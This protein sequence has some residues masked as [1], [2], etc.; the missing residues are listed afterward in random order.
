MD[1]NPRESKGT[2]ALERIAV[3]DNRLTPNAVVA[4]DVVL[5]TL[6]P[7]TMIE[8]RWQVLLLRR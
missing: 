5:F 8:D 3:P 2:Q 6:R 1:S 7:T 4:V